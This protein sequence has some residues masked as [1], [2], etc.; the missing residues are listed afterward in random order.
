MTLQQYI[1][2]L[3]NL[4]SNYADQG[5][6]I[7][8]ATYSP[9]DLEHTDLMSLNLSFLIFKLNVTIVVILEDYGEE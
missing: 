3:H 6:N 2:V 1:V 8:S 9:G 7:S 5:S 4:G